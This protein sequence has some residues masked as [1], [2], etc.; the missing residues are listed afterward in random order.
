MLGFTLYNFDNKYPFIVIV[1]V[2]VIWL[3]AIKN[4]YMIK[5]PNH[6]V[7]CMSYLFCMLELIHSNYVIQ[8]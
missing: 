1:I 2:I 3:I 7:V 8:E 4:I 5:K 6:T